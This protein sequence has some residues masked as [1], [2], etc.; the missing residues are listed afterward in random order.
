MSKTE[1]RRLLYQYNTRFPLKR[2]DPRQ[3]VFN[4]LCKSVSTV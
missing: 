3:N 1:D 2:R 4:Y